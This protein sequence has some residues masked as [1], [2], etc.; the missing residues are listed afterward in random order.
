MYDDQDCRA[1]E[2]SYRMTN[3]R[4]SS[5]CD[6]SRI[7][8]SLQYMPACLRLALERT[9]SDARVSKEDLSECEPRDGG[10]RKG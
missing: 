8:K 1:P 5:E 6:R 4:S 9:T 7:L 2:E 3:G 10:R